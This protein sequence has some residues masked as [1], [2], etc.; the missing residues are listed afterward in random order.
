MFY[1]F[2][3]GKGVIF[4]A[5]EPSAHPFF[6]HLFGLIPHNTPPVPAER[7]RSYL[8]VEG[9]HGLQCYSFTDHIDEHCLSEVV[10]KKWLF[11]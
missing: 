7:E 1:I 4:M 10:I 2:A 9:T 8:Q 3:K 11:E 6:L 5:C